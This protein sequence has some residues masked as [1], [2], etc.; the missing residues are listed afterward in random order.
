MSFFFFFLYYLSS[1]LWNPAVP[2]WGNCCC[3]LRRSRRHRR[4]RPGWRRHCNRHIPSW[5]PRVRNRRRNTRAHCRR[6]AVSLASS[7]CASC[8]ATWDN[9]RSA[10]TKSP[11]P[12]SWWRATLDVVDIYLSRVRHK[13]RIYKMYCGGTCVVV[14]N[15]C[16]E[17]SN[18]RSVSAVR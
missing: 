1:V 14:R 16:A 7:Y 17:D 3:C 5:P 9:R 10:C 11:S 15:I 2:N 6:I 13:K 8:T 4:H 18:A 12:S